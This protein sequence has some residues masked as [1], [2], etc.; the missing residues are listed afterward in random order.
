MGRSH[1]R[2]SKKNHFVSKGKLEDLVNKPNDD[3]RTERPVSSEHTTS[4]SYSKSSTS[5]HEV[6]T[7]TGSTALDVS[8]LSMMNSGGL[9]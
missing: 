9:W 6:G 7:M 1:N 2:K 4:G 5:S 3:N 8:T